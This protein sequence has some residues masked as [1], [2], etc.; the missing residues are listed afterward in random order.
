MKMRIPNGGSSALL[1]L[2]F[3][4]GFCQTGRSADSFLLHE[5]LANRD[6]RAAMEAIPHTGDLE[7][8]DSEGRTPL[9]LAVEQVNPRAYRVVQELLGRGADP[10]RGCG[11]GTLP[12]QRAITY[13]NPAVVEALVNRGADV[14]AVEE[15]TGMRPVAMAYSLG[16]LTMAEFLEQR[17]GR[18]DGEE[19]TSALKIHF[20]QQAFMQ[21]MESIT[22]DLPEEELAQRWYDAVISGYRAAAAQETNPYQ[23]RFEALWIGKAEQRRYVR[24]EGETHWDWQQKAVLESM[25]EAQK[26]MESRGDWHPEKMSDSLGAIRLKEGAE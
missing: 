24:V 7:A 25:I 5:A 3:I 6:I 2:C 21:G 14:S 10:N 11:E 26:E 18:I 19:R 16:N 13:G 20:Y 17:G 4:A 9:C 22:P 12:L 1:A 23:K 8:R 15:R